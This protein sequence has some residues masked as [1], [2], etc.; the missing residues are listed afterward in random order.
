[1]ITVQSNNVDV[2]YNEEYYG[3]AAISKFL[4]YVHPNVLVETLTI[5]VPPTDS[6]LIDLIAGR[7]AD[8]DAFQVCASGTATER[9]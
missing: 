1:M 9:L 6:Q 4:V 2:V 8:M 5:N 3:M 7:L